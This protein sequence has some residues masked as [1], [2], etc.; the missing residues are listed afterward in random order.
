[1]RKFKLLGLSLLASVSIGLSGNITN[2]SAAQNTAVEVEAIQASNTYFHTQYFPA[3]EYYVNKNAIW[4]T[5][6]VNGKSY[7]GYIYNRGIEGDGRTVKFNGTLRVGA[8]EPTSKPE[9]IE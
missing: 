5:K 1:M 9:S 6:I 7:S 8:Y 2:V 4:V 3:S